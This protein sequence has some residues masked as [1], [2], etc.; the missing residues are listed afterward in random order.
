MLIHGLP[1]EHEVVLES[2][3]QGWQYT[4]QYGE[5]ECFLQI[6]SYQDSYLTQ[7]LDFLCRLEL[8]LERAPP[9]ESSLV[10]D[11]LLQWQTAN[12]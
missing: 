1:V 5:V 12:T 10:P 6:L 9:R 8:Y 4:M 2:S 7:G 11:A 3:V